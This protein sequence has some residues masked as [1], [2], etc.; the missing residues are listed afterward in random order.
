MPRAA[1]RWAV[2]VVAALLLALLLLPPLINVS[3]FRGRIATA[4][5]QALDRDVTVDEVHLQL[6]P[7]PGFDLTRMVISE[8]PAFGT[9]P[10]LHADEVTAFLRLTSLWR[11]RL[12]ISR[13][14]MKNPSLNLVLQGGRWNLEALLA[15]ASQTPTAPTA[16][17]RPEARPRFPYIEAEGARINLKLGQEKKAF[18]L[19]EADFALWLASEDEW[20]MRLE[21]RPVR[22]DANLSDSGTLKVVGAFQRAA[23]LGETPLNLRFSLEKAQLGQLS[24]LIYGRDRGWRGALD[25]SGSLGGS[26]ANLTLTADALLVG[27]RRYDIASGAPLRAQAHCTAHYSSLTALLSAL[28]CHMPVGDGELSARGTVSGPLASPRYDL[29][30]TARDLPLPALAGLLRNAK[31]DLAADLNASGTLDAVFS[32]HAP[33]P[34]AAPL[35][36]GGGRTSSVRLTSSALGAPLELGPISFAIERGAAP[37]KTQARHPRKREAEPP[38]RP[39]LLVAPFA[40]SLDAPTPTV[41]RGR[42]DDLGYH[43]AFEG[44]AEIS[45]LLQAAQTL[46]LRPPQVTARGSAHLSL[47]LAGSWLDFAPPTALGS[48]QLRNLEAQVPG[49]AAPL[50]LTGNALLSD[51]TIELQNLTASVPEYRLALRGWVRLPRHCDQSEGCP[52]EFDLSTPELVTD[53]LNRLLNPQFRAQLWYQLTSSDSDSGLWRFRAQGHLAAGRVMVKSLVA[54]GVEAQVRLEPGKLILTDV[55]A[56]FLGGHHLGDWN[57]DFTGSEPL[58]LGRGRLE[59]ASL[60]RLGTLMHDP[61]GTGALSGDYQITLTGWKA[62]DLAR[63]AVGSAEFEWRNGTLPRLSLGASGPLRL[64]RFSGRLTLRDRTLTFSGAHLDAVGGL[65]SLSG[66]ASFARELDLTLTAQDSRQYAV[67]GALLRPRVS[68]PPRAPR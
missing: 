10:M 12:E 15:R 59:R 29:G 17:T 50:H 34:D 42:F 56:E 40:V 7:L 60:E 55:A 47:E 24:R 18:A 64:R 9:E 6:L 43:V 45:R 8:D 11:G 1:K 27:F 3:R 5:G 36:A 58:Y 46:G 38:A 37:A 63:T 41:V 30:F 19:D 20:G 22:T 68:S 49:L 13:L 31:K 52:A 26:P 51:A 33:S 44:D 57:A 4:I 23:R 54:T 48:A 28:E 67:T 62:E 35:W 16:R 32:L 2:A 53:E 21:A 39:T 14:S 65:Y 61:W 66:T 25:L